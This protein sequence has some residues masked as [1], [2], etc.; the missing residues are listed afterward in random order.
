MSTIQFSVLL[1][2]CIGG[3]VHGAASNSYSDCL[4]LA[5]H[6]DTTCNGTAVSN[7]LSSTGVNVSCSSGY[8]GSNCPGSMVGST[9]IFQH[10]LCVTCTNTS[11]V[12]IRV[13]TNGLPRYCPNVPA[14]MSEINIDYTVNFNPDVSVNSP[15]HNPTTASAL[16]AIV[17]SIS[18]Q[19][20]VP[21]ASNYVATT[22]AT[23]MNTLAGVSIDGVTIL[24]VN[25]AN[26]VDPFFPTGGFAVET[27]D[28]CL[29]HPNPSNNGYHYHAGSGCALTRPSGSISTCASTSACNS[30][31]ATYS[32]STFSSYR[33]LT[34]IGIAKD[35]HIIYGPYTSAGVEVRKNHT[36]YRFPSMQ[37]TEQIA[38]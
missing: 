31:V 37:C 18:S 33:T 36:C 7:I 29:G 25:S 21:S 30:N 19:A 23:N 4:A 9:C 8:T 5:A 28:A 16:T 13:Q 17:C 26:N 6:F 3:S 27:V 10:K 1:L 15:V 14:A 32:I 38:F 34:V 12:R 2:L 11:P 24:N 22:G 35:G 20:S